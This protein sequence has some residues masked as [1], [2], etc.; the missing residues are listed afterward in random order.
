[1]SGKINLSFTGLVTILAG[2]VLLAS[3]LLLVINTWS[4]EMTEVNPWF[5]SPIGLF[6]ALIG[7]IVMISRGE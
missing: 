7:I 1:M 5:L 3:G 2:F 4:T 6:L